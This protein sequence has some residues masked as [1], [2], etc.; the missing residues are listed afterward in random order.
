MF[1][2]LVNFCFVLDVWVVFVILF[3]VLMLIFVFVLIIVGFL[4][5]W[6]FG[7]F[8]VICYVVLVMFVIVGVGVVLF[9]G[10]FS[11]FFF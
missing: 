1:C 8:C 10:G 9:F 5:W 6:F 4:N 2:V 7:V 11:I 3:G